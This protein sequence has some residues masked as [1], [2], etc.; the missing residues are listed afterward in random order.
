MRSDAS[1]CVRMRS[2]AFGHFQKILVEKC[3]FRNFGEVFEELR[4]VP[5]LRLRIRVLSSLDG[6]ASRLAPRV[7]PTA[8]SGSPTTVDWFPTRG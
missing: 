1:G 4:F 7:P 5:S 6:G 2:D 8:R 3:V